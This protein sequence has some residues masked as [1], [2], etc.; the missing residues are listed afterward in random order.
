MDELLVI[1]LHFRKP[2]FYEEWC[3]SS[4]FLWLQRMYFSKRI[5]EKFDTSNAPQVSTI[6]WWKCFR[7]PAHLHLQAERSECGGT[8]QVSR[9]WIWILQNIFS[10]E[11][12]VWDWF[13]FEFEFKFEFW[14]IFLTW[15]VSL[16]SEWRRTMQMS[17]GTGI[18]FHIWY[19][20][21]YMEIW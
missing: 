6:E 21:P 10:F 3:F 19:Q 4:T 15:G 12:G 2:P 14:K 13:E 7:I 8:R 16:R 17:L 20:L 9:P 1:K 18:N 5:G 11:V